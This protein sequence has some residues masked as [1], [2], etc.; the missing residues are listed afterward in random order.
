MAAWAARKRPAFLGGAMP[1]SYGSHGEGNCGGD[2][3]RVAHWKSS[4]AWGRCLPTLT[5]IRR[6]RT[7][8]L[9]NLAAVN[10]SIIRSR[11]HETSA[12]CDTIF[13]CRYASLAFSLFFE[14][15]LER[16]KCDPR[17]LADD[18][19]VMFP[20]LC[21]D[22]LFLTSSSL[23]SGRAGA[24]VKLDPIGAEMYLAAS[25]PLYVSPLM[26]PLDV[27]S[28]RQ[29][30]SRRTFTQRSR[31]FQGL[32]F[33]FSAMT[34]SP[35]IVR[36]AATMSDSF[37]RKNTL[38][39]KATLGTAPPSAPL[40]SCLVIRPEVIDTAPTNETASN[41]EEEPTIDDDQVPTSPS[42][43]SAKKRVV[44]ADAKGLSLTQV[45]MMTEPSD[46]PPRWTAEFLEQVTGGASAEVGADRW[47]LTFAQPASD[48]LD[49][50]SR[51]ERQNVSLENVVVND[52]D[53]QLI[54][55][56]KVKNL[57]YSKQVTI[58]VTFD[59]WQSHTDVEATFAPCGLQNSP[60]NGTISLFDTFSFK[61]QI[62]AQV[63]SNKIQFCVRFTC[64]AGEFW[65]N[66]IGRN[67]VIV[68][69]VEKPVKNKTTA[70]SRPPL[71]RHLKAA[72]KK[73]PDIYS[74]S[75][76]KV[77]LW[78]DFASW[79]HLVNDSPYW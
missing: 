9:R 19:Y 61:V 42:R 51:L 67:Y 50:R 65:D 38:T 47:E 76:R 78:S 10:I 4:V 77:D 5:D 13:A 33:D 14:P 64:D 56:V 54:G 44:F 8:I 41:D 72:A 23:N 62:P 30:A 43:T 6:M 16:V 37:G 18:Y 22:S 3:V 27:S 45:K 2:V 68:K 74:Q 52:A 35:A 32:E 20:M 57:S 1:L 29:S 7:C 66:N 70:I 39:P 11:L 40:R 34:L 17:T 71:N 28:A 55:T 48:Y 31:Q 24:S 59:A 53:Q 60:S 36:A 46:C 25:P 12:K 75:P 49:F 69:P 15:C 21:F 58:R 63:A 26:G 73:C 79:N